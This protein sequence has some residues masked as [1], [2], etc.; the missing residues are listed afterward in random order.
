MLGGAQHLLFRLIQNVHTM[1]SIKR[2]LI[3][4]REMKLKRFEA[5]K[6]RNLSKQKYKY[7]TKTR[8]TIQ[9]SLK[10]DSEYG[11][12]C[13]KP[14]M[15]NI[16]F[17]AAKKKQFLKDLQCSSPERRR[18][19]RE[20]ILQSESGEWLERRRNLLTASW[21]GKICKRRMISCAPL[22]KTLLYGRSLKNIESIKYG[23]INE[24]VAMWFGIFMVAI[25]Q[26]C[27]QESITIEKSGLF[28]DPEHCFFLSYT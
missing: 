8:N 12:A 19:E 9:N 14:D 13:Q 15:D 7:K 18:I 23:K 16:S 5:S 11:D 28:I 22:V 21:F 4:A 1:F 2:F 10:P 26:L 20:T 17:D 6:H 3:A 27:E 25:R 24:P